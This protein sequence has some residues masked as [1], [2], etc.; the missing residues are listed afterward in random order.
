MKPGLAECENAV[1]VPHIASA[2]EW[3]RSGMVGLLLLLLLDLLRAAA[4]PTAA[5]SCC[6]RHCNSLL[7]GCLL[8]IGS[9][10]RT[11]A[12]LRAALGC[13]LFC[14]ARPAVSKAQSFLHFHLQ[15]PSPARWAPCCAGHA[16]SSQRGGHLARLPGL[17]Q[18]RRAAL[19][20]RPLRPDTQ[21]RPLHRQRQ[22]AGPT[23]RL[24][25]AESALGP[26]SWAPLSHCLIWAVACEEAT[27]E[28][29]LDLSAI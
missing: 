15:A 1:V 12:P 4:A 26:D 17:E 16:R 20:G 5:S 25:W 18:A 11:S 19:R 22:G 28:L 10:T 2:T 27:H 3:T 6:C 8:L 13:L 21:G 7:C 23:H 29:S 24:S 14:H 9:N